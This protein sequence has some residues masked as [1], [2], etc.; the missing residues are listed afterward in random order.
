M[1][2]ILKDNSFKNLHELIEKLV[3]KE[4]IDVCSTLRLRLAIEYSKVFRNVV[5]HMSLDQ[6]KNLSS[7]SQ[8]YHCEDGFQKSFK[9]L[10]D[11]IGLARFI[12]EQMIGVIK[13]NDLRFA[14]EKSKELKTICE[15]DHDTELDSFEEGI[16]HMESQMDQMNRKLSEI[17]ED[18]KKSLIIHM[19]YDRKNADKFD[20]CSDEAID[21]QNELQEGADA[22]FGP[23]NTVTLIGGKPTK[24]DQTLFQFKITSNCINFNEYADL[25]KNRN[26][27]ELW[28]TMKNKL[29]DKLDL[30]E[31]IICSHWEI[32]SLIFNVS[33]RK[34]QNDTW[35]EFDPIEIEKRLRALE[36]LIEEHF[37]NDASVDVECKARVLRR[38]SEDN[39]TSLTFRIDALSDDVMRQFETFDEKTFIQRLQ[40][41]TL[42]TQFTS[43]LYFIF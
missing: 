7:N 20:L 4:E 39:I 14:E 25:V 41:N 32:G 9:T 28:E 12:C 22:F 15:A 42:S 31:D 17:Q 5:F 8:F 29:Q 30:D 38:T 19:E 27:R 36:K 1:Y 10:A 2:C 23:G 40:Q 26:A 24:G 43:K 33:L 37:N 3:K 13:P 34:N 16:K 18:V 21:I 11:L 35:Q 6:W